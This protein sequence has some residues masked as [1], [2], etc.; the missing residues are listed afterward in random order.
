MSE[1]IC[2]LCGNATQNRCDSCTKFV[3]VGCTPDENNM[4]EPSCDEKDKK[5]QDLKEQV[6]KLVEAGNVMYS[7]LSFLADAK[8][9]WK[10]AIESHDPN[11]NIKL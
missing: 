9:A 1:T 11:K 3:C 8:D 6:A 4:C 10:E 2:W 7:T 5:I